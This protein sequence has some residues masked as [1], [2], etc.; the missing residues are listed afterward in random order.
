MNFVDPIAWYAHHQ[1][2]QQN[3]RIDN[4]K[5]LSRQGFD[6]AIQRGM[7]E[8]FTTSNGIEKVIVKANPELVVAHFSQHPD[9]FLHIPFDPSA[10]AH[11][12]DAL[13]NTL[14]QAWHYVRSPTAMPHF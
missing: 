5:I 11:N 3:T 7:I 2:Q 6:R 8:I 10:L 9:L 12:K 4:Q 14:T 13:E 1:A